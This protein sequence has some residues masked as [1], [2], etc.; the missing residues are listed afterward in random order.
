M[1]RILQF[2]IVSLSTT[3]LAHDPPSTGETDAITDALAQ[4]G[5]TADPDDVIEHEGNFEVMLAAC[6]DGDF[7]IELSATF[8]VIM[9]IR[10]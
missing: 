5:C 9:K 2:L 4:I 7:F 10:Q 3:A 1:A 6:D 8:D